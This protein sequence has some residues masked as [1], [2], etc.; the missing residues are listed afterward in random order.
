ML[1]AAPEAGRTR[2]ITV[3]GAI[4]AG[5]VLLLVLAMVL[6]V[7]RRSRRRPAPSAA[8]MAGAASVPAAPGWP[9]ATLPPD[10]TPTEP[11]AAPSPRDEGAP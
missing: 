2:A 9:Y 6:V 11:P 4:A 1:A 5:I 8:G 3:G 7:R 10:G